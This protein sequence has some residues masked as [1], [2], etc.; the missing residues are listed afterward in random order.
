MLTRQM[1]KKYAGSVSYGRGLDIYESGQVLSMEVE[2]DDGGLYEIHARVRGSGRKS[3]LV[4]MRYDPY[5]EELV[6]VSC[7]CPA[8]YSYSGICKHCVAVLIAFESSEYNRYYFGEPEENP[9]YRQLSLFEETTP[10]RRKTKQ[11]TLSVKKL[12][13]QQMSRKG[14]M[15]SVGNVR[16]QIKLD[17]YLTCTKDNISLEFRIGNTRMY[18]IKDIYEFCENVKGE[19]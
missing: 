14:L 18:V 16:E 10:K 15:L 6:S 1:I 12:L 5:E 11:T 9:F 8:F 3:Y 4:D 2:E 17:P 13:Q 7:E 19:G